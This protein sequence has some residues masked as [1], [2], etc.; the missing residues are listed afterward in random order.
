[1]GGRFDL[2]RYYLGNYFCTILNQNSMIPIDFTNEIVQTENDNSVSRLWIQPNN[3]VYKQYTRTTGTYRKNTANLVK[4]YK[5][6][7]LYRI[8][9]IAMPISLVQSK[10][11]ILGYTMPY[12]SGVDFGSFIRDGAISD[13]VKLSALKRLAKVITQLPDNVILGDLHEKNVLVKP[14]SSIMIID[15]DGFSLKNGFKISCPIRHYSDCQCIRKNRKYFSFC[16]MPI[17][18]RDSDI[19]CF[20]L[21]FLQ[22]M[23][24]GVTLSMYIE[25][26]WFRYFQFLRTAGFPTE[27]CDMIDMLFESG[28][29]YI[30]ISAFEKIDIKTI[31]NYKYAASI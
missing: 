28:S 20:F 15:V 26:E 3:I 9:E 18:S 16:G 2:Y 31:S 22:W 19:L 25:K 10:T 29:N 17:I 12:F 1:M 6:S 24:G 13:E 5:C 11:K 21:L 4:I 7:E 27:I 23:A 14:D 30:N 8:H